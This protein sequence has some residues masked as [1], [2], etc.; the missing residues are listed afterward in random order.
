MQ[1]QPGLVILF[2]SGE[3]SA[4]GRRVYDWLFRRLSPP[5]RVAVLETPAG[6]QPNSALVAQKVADFLRHRLQNYRPQ[7]MVIPARKRDTPFSPDDPQIVAPLLHSNVIFLGPGSPTYAVRQL[8]D[9][10]AWYTLLARHRLGATIVFASAATIAASVYALPVYEIY[11]VGADLY[12][13]PGLDFFGPFGLRLVFVSHWDNKEGGAELD[14]SRAFVGQVRF[15]QLRALLPTGVKV[16]G[17]DEHTALILDLNAQICQ[18]KG[19][20]GVT[21]CEGHQEQH[22]RDGQTFDLGVLGAFHLPAPWDGIPREVW[23]RVQSALSAEQERKV[24]QPPPEVL[25][26]LHEREV[27]RHQRDWATADALRE[28][29]AAMGWEVRDTPTGPELVPLRHS[30]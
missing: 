8:K 15:E 25:A 24:D 7:V 29:I 9:S 11:K 4:S 30:D 19:C 26:L 22:F 17:I 5:I 27:A 1:T 2:S 10:L 16:I 28:H 3:T 21:V 13:H 12:W 18:V 14:T 23:E 20:G 6:F